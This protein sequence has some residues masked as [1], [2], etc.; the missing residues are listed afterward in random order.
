MGILASFPYL[1]RFNIFI[2]VCIP[3][4]NWVNFGNESE[5]ERFQRME[6]AQKRWTTIL[7]TLPS[8]EWV[9]WGE[10]WAW[11]NAGHNSVGQLGQWRIER[12]G[13]GGVESLWLS[14][15]TEVLHGRK[16]PT[17]A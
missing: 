1:H 11:D 14:P 4:I 8:L 15:E 10:T 5:T 17:Y 7:A 13:E 2:P 3:D 6:L 12:A 16:W 9:H